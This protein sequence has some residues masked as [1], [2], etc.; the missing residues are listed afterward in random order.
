MAFQ[1]SK[2]TVTGSFCE[3]NFIGTFLG[4][5]LVDTYNHLQVIIF[6]SGGKK[7]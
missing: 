2:S 6:L 4:I 3:R 7:P 5:Q 1:C